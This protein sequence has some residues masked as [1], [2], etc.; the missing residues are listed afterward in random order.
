[1]ISPVERLTELG[2][3]ATRGTLLRACD[4]A[5]LERAIA[6]GDV[7]RAGRGRYVLGTVDDHTRAVARLGGVLCL[8][9]AALRRGWAVKTVPARPEVLVAR[10]RRL[11]PAQVDRVILHRGTLEADDVVDGVTSKAR[12]MLDCLRSLP[13]DEA[14]AVA[15]SALREGESHAWLAAIAR[16]ARGPGSRQARHIAAIADGR[17]A[18][19]FESVL[20]WI[21]HDVEGLDLRPQVEIY[22][23]EWLGRPDLVDTE[24]GI[25][26]EADS[27]EWHGGR[28]DLVRDARRYNALVVRGWLV[29][30][31]SWDDAMHRPTLVR[32]TLVAAVAERTHRRCRFGP[33]A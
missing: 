26:V 33:V 1:M 28:A 16:D 20:R 6:G 19:P 5:A 17:A 8:T 21:A 3:V 13:G 11:V 27:F 4:R 22:D 9:S 31:F 10:N 24:L 15:D 12:T 2:G 14:L 18:N 23:P 25:V 7:V 30:R 29:L 32:E